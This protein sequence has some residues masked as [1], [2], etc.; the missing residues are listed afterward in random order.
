M[1]QEN[2]EFFMKIAL[3]EAKKSFLI[4][5]VPV[6]AVLVKNNL[7]IAKA[8]NLVETL[9]DPSCHAE[10]LC[11]QEG[12]RVLGNWRLLDCTLYVTLEP[13]AMCFGAIV[14]SRIKKI[15]WAAPDIRHGACG[16]WVNLVDAGHPI[17]Q[18][19]SQKGI[20]QEESSVLLKA[21]LNKE[22]KKMQKRKDLIEALDNLFEEMV[23]FQRARLFK[24][25]E[26]FIPNITTDDIL[27]PN[28]FPELENSPTF[29]YEE[30]VVEGLLTAQIAY[31]RLKRSFSKRL[32]GMFSLHAFRNFFKFPFFKKDKDFS[33]SL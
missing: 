33:P 6:G 31:H 4:G 27:Q 29:R 24:L 32:V 8:H 17:H 12:A 21:F 30:G 18:I 20:L 15:V 16:S 23:F 14:L 5:E 3:E 26:K 10:M 13:C 22:G 11:I 9:K 25:A 2:E 7:I 19:Q 1:S 28:D